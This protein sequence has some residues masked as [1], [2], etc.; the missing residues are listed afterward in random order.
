[1]FFLLRHTRIPDPFSSGKAGKL[2]NSYSTCATPAHGAS[3]KLN[4]AQKTT[5]TTHRPSEKK[6]N[7]QQPIRNI[8]GGALKNSHDL[9]MKVGHE[10]GGKGEANTEDN[11]RLNGTQQMCDTTH[12]NKSITLGR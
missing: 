7:C 12:S 6:T 3:K 5:A 10:R 9:E 11:T 2:P 1:M 8:T 4:S